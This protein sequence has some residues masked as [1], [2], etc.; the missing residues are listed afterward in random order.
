MVGAGAVWVANS[1]DGTVTRI[2]PIS[3]AVKA[4]IPVGDGPNGLAV[5]PGAIWVSNELAGTI[6][7][8]DR[9]RGTVVMT[10]PIGNRPEGVAL[11]SGA[12]YVAVRASGAG[13]DGGTLTVLAP[14]DVLATSDPSKAYFP[15]DVQLLA[16][17]NDGLTGFRRVGGSSGA[18][19]V[20]DLAVSLPVPTDGGRTYRFQLR[21]GIR[22]STGA[23]VRPQDF[24]RA[25]ERSLMQGITGDYFSRVVGARECLA[26]R[27]RP[28]DLSRGIATDRSSKTVI[29]RLT[30]PDPEFL[31][32]LTLPS[33]Y[34]VPD[35]TPLHVKRPLPA[36]G[37]YMFA[38]Y[39]KKRVRLIR[40]PWFHEW[41]PIAQPRGF[42]DEIVERF[43]GTPDAHV[44]AVLRGTADIAE[45]ASRSSPG[46]LAACRR[47]TRASS[48]SARAA[49]LSC[50]FSTR[51]FRRSTMC[52]SAGH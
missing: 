4:T 8:I 27:S 44:K 22:Y 23:L 41:S 45:D 6:M 7:K 10:V 16:L 9:A 1:L 39:D 26:A 49:P 36:T 52:A 30:A 40:N 19:V 31:A 3:N 2:D 18:H 33:A 12:L 13:H 38:S 14:S 51:G 34:A 46:V 21:P 43:G 42:P 17:T 48:S 47:S 15:H 20:P 24:R 35:G 11:G 50:S 37:P 25:I 29:F 32:K 5:T 28:C